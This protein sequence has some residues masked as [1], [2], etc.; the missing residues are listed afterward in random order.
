MAKNMLTLGASFEQCLQTLQA[1]HCQLCSWSA[2][3]NS[4]SFRR[5]VK[6]PRFLQSVQ[7][8][9]RPFLISLRLHTMHPVPSSA[10]TKF[11]VHIVRRR[12]FIIA[13]ECGG[14]FG[15]SG[16]GDFSNLF[17]GDS[18]GCGSTTFA[19]FFGFAVSMFGSDRRFAFT[20]GS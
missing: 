18:T 7:L 19:A 8:T 1:E 6:W 14:F 5:H 13:A 10:M 2:V 4:F 11:G 12:L 20:D 16:L 9:N 3:L 15:F 17:T